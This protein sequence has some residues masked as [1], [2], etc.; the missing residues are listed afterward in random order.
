MKYDF[1]T[2]E[3]EL[4]NTWLDTV[5]F[6]DQ[7]KL[8][9]GSIR[10]DGIYAKASTSIEIELIVR[11]ECNQHCKYCYIAQHGK[12]LYPLEERTSNETILK[13]LDS[14][15]TYI[16][17]ERKIF[18]NHY[19]LFAGDMFYDDLF[20]DIC[21][22]F[23]KHLKP[24]YET[25][26]KVFE[27]ES[28]FIVIPC[29]CSFVKDD[30]KVQKYDEWWHK[31]QDLHVQMFI[32]Y[33]GD[34]KYAIDSRE[35]DSSIND[36]FYKKLFDFLDKYRYLCHPMIAPENIKNGIKTFDWWSKQQAERKHN[37]NGQDF[38]PMFLEVRNDYWSE[39]N[40]EDYRK[41]LKHIVEDRL[42]RCHNDIDELAYHLFKG[43]GANNTLKKLEHN[44]LIHFSSDFIHDKTSR[45]M[46][47]SIQALIHITLNNLSIVPCHRTSYPQFIGGSFEQNL[48]GEIIGIKP[49]N[50]SL[51]LTTR[52]T[53]PNFN[54]KCVNCVVK[55]FCQK[56]C[57]GAQ[58]E[59]NG[60][61]FEPALTVCKMHK[62]KYEY[63]S[64]LLVE[65]GVVESGLKQGILDE[66]T[67]HYYNFLHDEWQNSKKGILNDE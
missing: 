10:A 61:L 13:N 48:N 29:N 39:E 47:C 54:P 12:E 28:F 34:G 40:L 1:Y 41:L 60:E 22:V 15:L 27:E 59:T 62:I 45:I 53:Q 19:E 43:D 30:K 51:Y 57:L 33:S 67:Y 31:F 32:S 4:L 25:Y 23:Y 8:R 5:L 21:E 56:G 52:Y 2:D 38:L 42:I 7:R 9:S 11:P 6:N 50:V 14:L 3:Q 66:Q 58:F 24:L 63:T 55:H 37:M 17:D 18:I 64:Y 20:F 49:K 16:Y 44:D 26:T 35:Q 65:M 46:S 36:D